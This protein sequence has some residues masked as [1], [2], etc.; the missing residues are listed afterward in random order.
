[1]CPQ[2]CKGWSSG[3]RYKALG[4]VVYKV[5]RSDMGLS[6][7]RLKFD[8]KK[9]GDEDGSHADSESGDCLECTVVGFSECWERFAD[10]SHWL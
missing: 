5:V 8:P 6:P 1:V 2:Q 7:D 3:V 10:D 9:K 4:E